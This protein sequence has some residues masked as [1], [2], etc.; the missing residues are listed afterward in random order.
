MYAVHPPVGGV[1]EPACVDPAM[2][3]HTMGIRTSARC[4]IDFIPLSI[5]RVFAALI[6]AALLFAARVNNSSADNPFPRRRLPVHVGP[7]LLK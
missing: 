3:T 1:C 6:F 5:E 7:M 4:D 2:H